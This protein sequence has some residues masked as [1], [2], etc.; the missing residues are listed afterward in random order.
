MCDRPARLVTPSPAE[1]AQLDKAFPPDVA[2]ALRYPVSFPGTV[3]A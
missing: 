1:L 2:A 3:N